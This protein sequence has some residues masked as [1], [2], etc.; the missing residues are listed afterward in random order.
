MSI[1]IRITCCI[2]T[3]TPAKA[4]AWLLSMS[5]N[6]TVKEA[7]V[8]MYA[9]DMANGNWKLSPQGI[10]FDE[11]KSL[12]DGQHRLLAV[13][14]CGLAIPMLII[15]GFPT[16]QGKM[17]TMD[18]VD[19]GAIR[20]LPDSLK[21]MGCYSGNPNL[22]CAIARQIVRLV[23]GA[24]AR[25]S[26]RISLAS[27]LEIIGLWSSEITQVAAVLD[28]NDFRPGRNSSV[29]AAFVIAA[30]TCPK[31]TA[32]SLTQ[33]STGANLDHGSPLLEL[34]NALISGRAGENAERTSFCLSALLCQ[35]H[36]M[37]GS[38]IFKDSNKAP[39]ENFF[40]EKQQD[41]FTRVA[42]LFLI[43]D[44]TSQPKS[45]NRVIHG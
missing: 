16:T 45:D 6:R 29:A 4:H 11:N 5:P 33:L 43:K 8:V 39:A 36:K 7:T 40:R 30:A 25:A 20:T 18:V 26:R 1:P 21:L 2:E 41:R 23:M 19:C 24:H 32:V 22:V 42:K 34:R 31:K 44:E 17:K 3:V 10:A 38:Q 15:R 27:T 13:I 9:S 28:R 14:R 12:F 37:P 35:W